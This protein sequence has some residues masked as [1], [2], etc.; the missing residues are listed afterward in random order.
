ME[1]WLYSNKAIF[2]PGCSWSRLWP[3]R[4]SHL[5]EGLR[6][7]GAHDS[8]YVAFQSIV[9]EGGGGIVSHVWPRPG[10]EVGQRP[11]ASGPK[12]QRPERQL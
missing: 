10:D 8:C 7:H 9:C 4:V 5:L 2:T 3:V 11:R 6:E 1:T 12:M